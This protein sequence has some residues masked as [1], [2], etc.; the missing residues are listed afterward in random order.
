MLYFSF[1]SYSIYIFNSIE[2]I[3][4]IRSIAVIF[5][6]LDVMEILIEHNLDEH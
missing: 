2:S 3:S 6:S 5:E 4:E 1:I